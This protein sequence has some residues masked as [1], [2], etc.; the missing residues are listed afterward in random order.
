MQAELRAVK[1]ERDALVKEEERMEVYIDPLLS[2]YK[3]I[4]PI[5]GAFVVMSETFH[6]EQAHARDAANTLQYTRNSV[7]GLGDNF[8]NMSH[9]QNGIASTMDVLVDTSEKIR[10]FVTLIEQISS[11]TNLLALNAAIEAA[12]AGEAGKG[13][14]VVAEEVR[15]LAG[16]TGDATKEIAALVSGI[17]ESTGQAKEEVTEAAVKAQDYVTI[18]DNTANEVVSVVDQSLRMAGAISNAAD[19]SFLNVVKM[20]H[21]VFKLNIYESF[22]KN[23]ATMRVMDDHNCRLGKWYFEGE[24]ESTF[25]HEPAFRELARPHF[26]VHDYA[27]Q[28]IAALASGEMD[29]AAA[30]LKAMETAS[31]RVNEIIEKLLR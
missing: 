20:D 2:C 4:E 12:R 29:K 3:S 5:R 7:S 10:S 16:R 22:M 6:T 9:T 19:N 30:T 26:E 15:E 27:A 21:F 18:A 25:G 8:K 31:D 23:N 1:T 17:S 24:G 11:Q 28:A 13:F 14:A